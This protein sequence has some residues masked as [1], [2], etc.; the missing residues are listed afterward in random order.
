VADKPNGARAGIVNAITMITGP[1][2]WENFG[3]WVKIIGLVLIVRWLWFEPFSIPSNSMFPTLHGD[4]RFL[5]GDRVAV[6]KFVYGP[7]VPFMNKRLWH[8]ADPKRWDVVVFRSPNKD[9]EHPILIKRIAGL[10]GERV[11]IKDGKICVNGEVQEFPDFMPP[12]MEYTNPYGGDG[13]VYRIDRRSSRMKYGILP[14]DEYSLI[15]EDHYLMLG[16][17]SSNSQDGRYFGWVPNKNLIGR[18]FCVWWPLANRRDLTGFTHT[19]WGRVILFGLPGL[20]V[21]YELISGFVFQSWRLRENAG[22]GMPTKDERIFVNRTA[23]GLRLPFTK[24]RCTQGRSPFR[25]EVV[26]YHLASEDDDSASPWL[27][28]VAGLSG[29]QIQVMDGHIQ[30]DGG[31]ALKISPKKRPF[32]GE[33]AEVPAGHCLVLSHDSDEKVDGAIL[34]WIPQEDLIGSVPSVWWPLGRARTLKS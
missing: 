22:P 7:R 17:N 11:H 13:G 33:R 27:G 10:P 28:R 18:A 16:D 24:K 34:N 19:F 9:A 25:N 2:T 26:M 12:D 15:P 1:W 20:F 32:R 14:D 29:D 8:G 21:L 3:G 23:F 6:N 4:E 31:D 30:I 5:K